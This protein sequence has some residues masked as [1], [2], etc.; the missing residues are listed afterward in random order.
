MSFPLTTMFKGVGALPARVTTS[1]LNE[2]V[3]LVGRGC[4]GGGAGVAGGVPSDTPGGSGLLGVAAGAVGC[5][6]GAADGGG[7]TAGK[8]PARTR[9]F[10]SVP[11]KM[12][13]R[14][15][16][17]ILGKRTICG[18]NITMISVVSRSFVEL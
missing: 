13:R 11:M 14:S 1:G 4:G 2:I 3:V 15:C 9:V 16:S 8:L 7:V 6:A 17:V 5:G 18:V 10:A 12:P